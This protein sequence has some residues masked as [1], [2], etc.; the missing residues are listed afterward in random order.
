VNQIVAE[1]IQ[2][3]GEILVS[4]IH[5]LINSIWN[6]EELTDQWKESVVV[7]IHKKGDKTDCNNYCVI[8]LLS[9]SYIMLMNTLLSLLIPYI[10]EII[11]DQQCGF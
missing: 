3:G 5:K 1:L 9:A 8:S 10:H 11:M 2:A 7:P 4:V 6:N